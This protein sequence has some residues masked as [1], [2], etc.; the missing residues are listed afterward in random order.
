MQFTVT[1]T[2]QEAIPS[3]RCRALMWLENAG[4]NDLWVSPRS[5]VSAGGALGG[6]RIKAGDAIFLDA[7]RFPWIWKPLSAICG[8]GTCLLNYETITN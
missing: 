8:A 3:E 4:I 2:A 1:T 6:I 5:D 7:G